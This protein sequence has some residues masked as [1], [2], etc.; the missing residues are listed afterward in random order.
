MAPL[1]ILNPAKE[2]QEH[3]ARTGMRDEEQRASRDIPLAGEGKAAEFLRSKALSLV[4]LIQ[5]VSLSP[6][7]P[8]GYLVCLLTS[9]GP[10]GVTGHEGVGWGWIRLAFSLTNSNKHKKNKCLAK[11]D[12][13]VNFSKA[14][15]VSGI[16]VLWNI[17]LLFQP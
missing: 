15:H 11:K 12:I 9:P 14:L 7:L 4:V 13:G 17:C 8:I 6:F 10:V 5:L 1:S 3:G 16:K 2:F